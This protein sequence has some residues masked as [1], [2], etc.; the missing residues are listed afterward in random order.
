M[1]ESEKQLFE[2]DQHAWRQY[3]KDKHMKKHRDEERE[4]HEKRM[5]GQPQP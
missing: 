3:K 1:T 5:K 2:A 4:K